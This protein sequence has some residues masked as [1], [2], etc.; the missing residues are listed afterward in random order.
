MTKL[1]LSFKGR[2]L[3]VFHLTGDSSVI[4]RDPSC[5]IVIDSLALAPRHARI[6]QTEDGAYLSALDP[7]QPVFLNGQRV[8]NALLQDG[9][10]ILVGKHTL[11]VVLGDDSGLELNWPTQPA[12]APR[13]EEATD[14]RDQVPAYLQ[15]QSGPAIGQVI[16]LTRAVTR[17]QRIG[18]T[19]VVVTRHG[20]LHLLTRIGE[21]NRV[22]VGGQLLQGDRQVQLHDRVRIDVDGTRCQFFD[23]AAD[24]D[25]PPG[26]APAADADQPESGN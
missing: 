8:D 12:A 7:A 20:G 15:V 3:A 11:S 4:G 9:D 14:G 16:P 18:G 25:A 5:D 6:S 13:R 10:V 19:E 23:P 21:A 24:L 1:T 22:E 26:V 17:L 2:L